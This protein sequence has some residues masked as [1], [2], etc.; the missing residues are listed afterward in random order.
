V[1][2]AIPADLLVNCTS[3]GRGDL[4]ESFKW[5]PVTADGLSAYQCIVDLVYRPGDTAL[6][7]AARA[8]RIAVVEGL[9]VLVRQ[10]ALSLEA[11]T[12]MPAP[13]EVMRTAA[14]QP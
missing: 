2:R 1:A 12:G 8:R 7:A 5:L 11:W 14:R 10:G 4:A 13:I 3:V 9:E 6:L